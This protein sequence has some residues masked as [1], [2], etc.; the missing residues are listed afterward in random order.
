MAAVLAAVSYSRGGFSPCLAG[1][2]RLVMVPGGSIIQL[3]SGTI[4]LAGYLS[5]PS[6]V[7]LKIDIAF[8]ADSNKI[9]LLIA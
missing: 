7:S 8:A 3:E 1:S 2:A 9:R 5:S 6:V 4:S